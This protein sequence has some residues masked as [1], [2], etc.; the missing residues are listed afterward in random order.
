MLIL[1]PCFYR[2]PGGIGSY[3]QW[4]LSL[5]EIQCRFK[6]F[7]LATH[8]EK[9]KF[10]KTIFCL[11]SFFLGVLLIPL[12][13]VV[14]IHVAG[15]HGFLRKSL[16][17]LYAKLFF[18][19]T[20]LHIHTADMDVVLKNLKGVLRWYFSKCFS[21]SS[22]IIA[23]SDY[24]NKVYIEFSPSSKI[25]TIENPIDVQKFSYDSNRKN[26]VVLFMGRIGKRKGAF[27]LIDAIPE[28]VRNFPDAM[29]VFDGDGDIEQAK[30]I[31]QSKSI[32]DNVVFRG[33]VGFS[34]KI[35]DL[36]NAQIFVLPTYAEGLPIAILEAMASGLPILSTKIPA[37]EAI[38]LGPAAVLVSPG[39]VS[40]IENSLIRL[41]SN[42]SLR[43]KMGKSARELA[44]KKFSNEVISKKLV[45]LYDNI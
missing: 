20:I 42:E 22:T 17:L 29:F 12:F 40:G 38:D 3:I 23:L 11:K 35:S 37:I 2:T 19:K 8:I 36:K 43:K 9:N 34:E 27:D 13:D 7:F 1:G 39:D 32:E 28:V 10:S 6:T 33:W 21:I 5:K 15:K 24:W 26:R 45:S 31:V 16:Y 30:Q 25:I 14:H 4:Q 44:V 41:L 18:K